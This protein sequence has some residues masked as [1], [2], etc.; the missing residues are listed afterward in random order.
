[1][2]ICRGPLKLVSYNHCT[3]TISNF[4]KINTKLHALCVNTVERV[5]GTETNWNWACRLAHAYE[6]WITWKVSGNVSLCIKVWVCVREREG[7][8][9]IGWDWVCV[10]RPQPSGLVLWLG[11]CIWRGANWRG[12]STS[13]RFV[14]AWRPCR[15]INKPRSSKFCHMSNHVFP[16]TSWEHSAP[17]LSNSLTLRLGLPCSKRRSAL[18]RGWNDESL[19]VVYLWAACL[20]QCFDIVLTLLELMV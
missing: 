16:S 1:M 8:R 12:V 6:V 4:P 2:V 7:E 9:E 15:W 17:C 5:C 20:A 3:A 18:Q 14:R 10:W 13:S 19:E 11:E